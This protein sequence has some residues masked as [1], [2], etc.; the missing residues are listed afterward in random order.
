[1]SISKKTR[2][3]FCALTAPIESLPNFASNGIHVSKQ[4]PAALITGRN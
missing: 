3:I 1:M 2:A 4:L